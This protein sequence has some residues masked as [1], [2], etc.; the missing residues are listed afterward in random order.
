MGP[1]C[2]IRDPYH[3]IYFNP[4][5]LHPLYA[6]NNQVFFHRSRGEEVSPSGRI[7]LFRA[8]LEF[9]IRIRLH[10]TN[11]RGL[12]IQRFARWIGGIDGNKVK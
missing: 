6:L 5:G 10:T 11:A 3:G 1:G 4:L 12:G 2:F 7:Q 8:Q 9:G